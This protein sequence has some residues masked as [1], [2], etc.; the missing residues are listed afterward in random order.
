MR[1]HHTISDRAMNGKTDFGSGRVDHSENVFPGPRASIPIRPELAF[2]V[3]GDT[4]I[5]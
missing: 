3:D 2:K 4:L 5:A 1:I